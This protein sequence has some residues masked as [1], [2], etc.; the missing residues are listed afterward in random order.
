LLDEESFLPRP[1]YWAALLWRRLMG[2]TV[3]DPGVQA[4]GLRVH[5]HARGGRTTLLVL[6]LDRK[7]PRTIAITVPSERYTLTAEP[8]DSGEVRLNGT[9]LALGG[10]ESLPAL[11]GLAAPAGA[12]ALPPGSITFLAT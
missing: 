11:T 1:N 9:P 6:N 3:L 4:D 5:A 10:D 8:L 7:Q 12:I 2:E